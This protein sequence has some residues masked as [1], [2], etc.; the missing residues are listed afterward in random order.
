[1]SNN[2][3]LF[4][5]VTFSIERHPEEDD[6]VKNPFKESMICDCFTSCSQLVFDRVFTTTTLE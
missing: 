1:M 6:F 4:Q 5:I 2:L 3:N